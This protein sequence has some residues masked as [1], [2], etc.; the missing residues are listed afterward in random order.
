MRRLAVPALA[1]AALLPLTGCGLELRDVPMPRL[2]SG[3]TYTVDSV[4]EHALNLPVGAPVKLDGDTV[5]EVTAVTAKDFRAHVRLA[6]RDTTRLPRGTRATVRLTAPMGESFVE[7]TPPAVAGG[8]TLRDGD[9]I[10]LAATT[11]S[12]D[13]TD[14]LSAMSLV[15]TGGSFADIRTIVTELN[16]ALSGNEQHVRRLLARLD[17]MVTGLDA[18]TADIDAVLDGLDRLGAR[19]ARDSGTLADAVDRLTPAVRTLAAQRAS[20]IR[21]LTALT[22]LG[23]TST[24][25]IRA[26]QDDLVRQLRDVGPVLD[27]VIRA[28]RQLTP[29]MR[30][31]RDFG[32]ELDDATPADYAMFDLNTLAA[33]DV[34]GAP[35]VDEGRNGGPP[36]LHLPDYPAPRL[37]GLPTGPSGSSGVPALPGIDLLT[38]GGLG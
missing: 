20:A 4:F 12:P 25:V 27:S 23:E 3:P 10:G 38:G 2:V 22:R 6:L 18:H 37:P 28:Q 17:A 33:L 32:R 34:N 19:L 15:V 14:L 5:G 16:T 8:G 11:A 1:L 35:L 7:L 29:I 36:T 24:R 30:G 13:T 26:T 9:V 31:V 21:M